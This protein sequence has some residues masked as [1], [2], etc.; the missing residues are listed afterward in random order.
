M[1]GQRRACGAVLSVF[2]IGLLAGPIIADPA[3]QAGLADLTGGEGKDHCGC[4]RRVGRKR[5][6]I[7]PQEY[8][9][10]HEGDPLVAIDKGV[11]LGQSERV[12]CSKLRHCRL[13]IAPFVDWT[14][15]CQSQ[16]AFVTQS[17]RTA[18]PAQLPGMDRNRLLIADPKRRLALAH[19]ASAASV[20]RYSSMT[21]SAISIVR[22]KSG[23]KGSAWKPPPGSSTIC[24]RWPRLRSSRCIS[25][26]GSSRPSE[27]PIFL[28]SI[29][30]ASSPNDKGMLY[31]C[32]TCLYLTF[33]NCI[34]PY[35][36]D[37]SS[38]I[39]PAMTDRPPSQKRG[40]LASRPNGLSSSE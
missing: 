26:R 25:S 35:P 10:G 23:S 34:T 27:L 33:N 5:D 28:I 38:S 12:S 30:M 3:R 36:I 6:P 31:K 29:F 40:S 1:Q 16:H 8:H 2:P 19:L 17:W 24:N 11:V 13:L 4:L 37:S 39:M 15:Q 18:E 9:H 20:S 14:L 21:S 32:I 7:A 22:S